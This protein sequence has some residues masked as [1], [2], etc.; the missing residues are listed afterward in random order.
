MKTHLSAVALA[1]AIVGG[2][3]WVAGQGTAPGATI[4]LPGAASAQEATTETEAVEITEMTLGAEDAPVEVIE[5]A[6]YTCP[7]CATFHEDVFPQLK[8][9]YIDSGKVRFTYREVY[10]DKYGMWASLVARCGGEDRFFGITDM[11][12]DTQGEWSRAGSDAA[13]ADELRKIGRMAGLDNDQL[14]SCLTDSAK[15]RALVEWYQANAEEH[16]VRATP[17][18]VIDGETRSNMS[19]AEFSDILDERLGE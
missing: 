19:Y 13:I 9:D 18:F 16:N 15:L 17:T 14:E 5:Y 7:H 11:I 3:W 2:G 8:E 12:Y 4:A 10:F 1:A 6:S